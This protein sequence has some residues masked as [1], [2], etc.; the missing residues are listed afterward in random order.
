[1]AARWDIAAVV[2]ALMAMFVSVSPTAMS[3]LEIAIRRLNSLI[4]PA[5][6]HCRRF[7]WGDVQ[8]GQLHLCN[9]Q[10]CSHVNGRATRL[11][12]ITSCWDQTLGQVFNRAWYFMNADSN[13]TKYVTKK[14]HQLALSEE[15]IQTD[16]QTL[17]AFLLLTTDVCRTCET[18]DAITLLEIQRSRGLVSI[19]LPTSGPMPTNTQ[20]TKFEIDRIIEGYP[21][22]YR[23][24]FTTTGGIIIPSPMT[25]TEHIPR[26]AWVLSVGMTTTSGPTPCLYNMQRISHKNPD[27]YWR[28]THVLTAFHMIGRTLAQLKTYEDNQR[29]HPRSNPTKRAWCEDALTC[30]N[31]I[32]TLDYSSQPWALKKEQIEES[33]L[34]KSVIGDCPCR[35]TCIGRSEHSV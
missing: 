1:M 7:V 20:F 8:D 27:V 32:M 33:D 24:H 15:Y 6:G 31:M 35:H 3:F 21:P 26:G 30:F 17:K 22:F 10:G 12:S 14:P 9:P 25:K 28:G 2:V 13:A 18:V 23:E 34:F 16:I 4:W 29:I 19:H 11:H 5:R